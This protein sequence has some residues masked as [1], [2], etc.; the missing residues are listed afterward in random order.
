M[1]L[2]LLLRDSYELMVSLDVMF[3]S[4]TAREGLAARRAFERLHLEQ[5]GCQN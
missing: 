3:Q 5:K 4:F 2:L 1:L